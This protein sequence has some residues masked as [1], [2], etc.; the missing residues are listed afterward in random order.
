VADKATQ[1]L[2]GNARRVATSIGRKATR[3]GL[4]PPRRKG[5]DA[6]VKCLINKADHLDYPVALAAKEHRGLDGDW[7]TVGRSTLD[8]W[9]V[10]YRAGSMG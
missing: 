4:N 5:T 8:R 7:K 6:C 2:A 9:V 10:G 3:D 1:V